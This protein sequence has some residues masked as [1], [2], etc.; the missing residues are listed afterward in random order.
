M[1]VRVEFVTA[2]SDDCPE[3]YRA[4][5]VMEIVKEKLGDRID[6][7][8]IDVL[9]A[10]REEVKSLANRYGIFLTPIIALNGKVFYSGKTPSIE[11][12]ERVILEISSN[13]GKTL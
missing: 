6:L 5:G 1:K 9:K 8:H 7:F 2:T 3:C 4:E 10:G 13:D 12:L 11:E